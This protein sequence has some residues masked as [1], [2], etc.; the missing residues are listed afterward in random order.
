MSTAQSIRAGYLLAGL[1][2]GLC[3]IVVAQFGAHRAVRR[4]ATWDELTVY[5][6]AAT[7]GACLWVIA[8]PMMAWRLAAKLS[9]GRAPSTGE[10]E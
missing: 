8:W 7:L 10:T 3:F 9:D 4:G 2:F 1:V 6:A 5:L